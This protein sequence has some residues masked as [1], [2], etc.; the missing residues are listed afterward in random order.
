MWEPGLG[1]PRGQPAAAPRARHA[2]PGR[3]GGGVCGRPLR[4]A[5]ARRPARVLWAAVSCLRAGCLQGQA[6][7]PCDLS[8]RSPVHR[9]AASLSAR[10]DTV[11][12]RLPERLRAVRA[13]RPVG[14]H[15]SVDDTPGKGQL[16]VKVTRQWGQGR[17][18]DTFR[19]MEK[20]VNRPGGEVSPPHPPEGF[21]HTLP[22]CTCSPARACEILRTQGELEP[23]EAAPHCRQSAI[24]RGPGTWL[25]AEDRWQRQAWEHARG[26]EPQS[27]TSPGSVLPGCALGR[28]RHSRLY[29][30]IKAK[31]VNASCAAQ[32]EGVRVEAPPAPAPPRWV[33]RIVLPVGA[34][35]PQGSACSRTGG[36]GGAL[37]RVHLL[38]CSARQPRASWRTGSNHTRRSFAEVRGLTFAVPSQN[39]P[40]IRNADSRSLSWSLSRSLSPRPWQNRD[41]HLRS[42]SP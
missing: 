25:V 5:L 17:K 2:P 36:G 7:E 26:S 37:P 20:E 40:R 9:A 42:R 31:K 14:G 21:I 38:L 3:A 33:L 23:G 22:S 18:A 24:P 34:R 8:V 32:T 10:R 27:P 15:H 30:H 12:E 28:E 11:P 39:A 6:R 4:P 16:S 13:R 41:Q 35:P 19:L 29:L 1:A